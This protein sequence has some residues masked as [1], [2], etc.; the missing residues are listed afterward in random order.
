VRREKLRAAKP[1]IQM[2]RVT[3]VTNVSDASHG[4]DSD[5]YAISSNMENRLTQ[6]ADELCRL[7]DQQIKTISERALS[8]LTGQELIDYQSRRERIEQLRT[9]LASFEGRN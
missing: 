2:L 1:S 5:S 6:I 9:E 7:F 4:R 3:K 8:D